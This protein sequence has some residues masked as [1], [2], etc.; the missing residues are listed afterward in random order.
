MNLNQTSGCCLESDFPNWTPPTL[1][2]HFPA[3]CRVAQL[4]D[5]MTDTITL[6][7]ARI[8]CR[9]PMEPPDT[10]SKPGPTR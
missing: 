1:W 4:D 2:K 5:I 9:R 8:A 3:P 7:I 6:L 10:R